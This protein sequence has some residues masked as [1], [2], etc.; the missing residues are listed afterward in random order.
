MYKCWNILDRSA[1]SSHDINGQAFSSS[2]L[3][4]FCVR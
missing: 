4:G 2:I 1:K 3:H